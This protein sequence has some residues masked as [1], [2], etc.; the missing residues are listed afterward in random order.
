MARYTMPL[1]DGGDGVQAIHDAAC[2]AVL[3][4]YRDPGTGLWT[5]TAWALRNRGFCCGE[6]CRHCPYADSAA[7]HPERARNLVRK[8]RAAP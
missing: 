1:S 8:R 6:G 3:P 4:M 2:V 5:M 7:E